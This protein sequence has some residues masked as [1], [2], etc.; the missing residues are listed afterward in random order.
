LGYDMNEIIPNAFAIRFMCM[1]FV[2]I[3]DFLSFFALQ[4][5][6]GYFYDWEKQFR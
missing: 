2:E 3:P 4:S 5:T 6:P 1:G